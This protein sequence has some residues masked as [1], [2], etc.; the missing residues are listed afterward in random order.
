MSDATTTQPHADTEQNTGHGKHRGPVSS[1]ERETAPS[2][3]H[4]KPVE[5]QTETAA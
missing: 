3:R 4:R 1:H 5:Q 2:G